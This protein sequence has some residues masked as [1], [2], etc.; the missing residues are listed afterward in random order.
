MPPST[1]VKK[2]GKNGGFD[3]DT[4]LATIGEGRKI[5]SVAKKQVIYAQG[6]E[7]DAIF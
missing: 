1:A 3:P 7:A 6:D 2:N 4:F 5:L